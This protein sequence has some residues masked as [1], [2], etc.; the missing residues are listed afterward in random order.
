MNSRYSTSAVCF[1]DE[2]PDAAGLSA[3][4]LLGTGGVFTQTGGA[5]RAASIAGGS[6][7][8]RRAI[9]PIGG[10]A[11]RLE[12]LMKLEALQTPD[13]SCGVYLLNNLNQRIWG[14]QPR[15]PVVGDSLQ[16]P[17]IDAGPVGWPLA[18]GPLPADEWVNIKIQILANG[19][20]YGRTIRMSDGALLGYSYS[21]QAAPLLEPSGIEFF[22]DSTAPTAIT[23]YSSVKVCNAAGS[24]PNDPLVNNVLINVNGA[25]VDVDSS[26]YNRTLINEGVV[27]DN[28]YLLNGHPTYRCTPGTRL[29]NLDSIAIASLQAA[30]EWCYEL[31][32]RYLSASFGIEGNINQFPNFI[33]SI[34]PG[35]VFR[36]I[37][38]IGGFT[39]NL[40]GVLTAGVFNHVAIIRDNTTHATWTRIH[41]AINGVVV[42]TSTDNIPKTE[43]ISFSGERVMG[44][45][46]NSPSVVFA[47]QRLTNLSRRY[48]HNTVGNP[49]N[50]FAPDPYPTWTN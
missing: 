50:S 33:L 49:V 29:R 43:A 47:G 19:L 14:I 8:A 9:A 2:F 30:N 22:V 27:L 10:P 5:I 25:G 23:F 21:N 6:A 28:T 24:P 36:M 42:A 41:L 35:L 26:T 32:I 40:T 34:T 1:T 4:T 37:M 7:T 48:L 45:D 38:I 15:A 12:V 16:R 17:Y 11:L 18:F 20:F 39:L 3:Y 31:N 13:D 46:I 44:F